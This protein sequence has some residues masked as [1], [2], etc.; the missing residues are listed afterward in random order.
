MIF[1]TCRHVL[2]TQ[3]YWSRPTSTRPR[4]GLSPRRK[5]VRTTH[6][7]RNRGRVDPWVLGREGTKG[8]RGHPSRSRTGKSQWATGRD[9]YRVSLFGYCDYLLKDLESQRLGSLIV[10]T[11]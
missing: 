5:D 11:S 9:P 10:V 2:D 6:H 1:G 3:E 4:T 7:R 8:L